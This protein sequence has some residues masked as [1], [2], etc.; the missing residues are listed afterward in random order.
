MQQCA[1]VV[2]L[3]ST[4]KLASYPFCVYILYIIYV[5][6]Y[7]V[8]GRSGEGKEKDIYIYVQA[9]NIDEEEIIRILYTTRLLQRKPLCTRILHVYIKRRHVPI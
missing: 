5:H 9:G 4:V 1:R 3:H 8:E 7:R 2:F 6:K